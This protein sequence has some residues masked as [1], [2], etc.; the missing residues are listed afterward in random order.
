VRAVLFDLDDTLFDHRGSS[1]AALAEVHRHHAPGTDFAAFER[2]HAEILEELHLEVLDGRRDLDDARR[3]RFRRVFAAMDVRLPEDNADAVAA[4]YRSG[5]VPAWRAVEGAAALVAA[6]RPHARIGVISNNLLAETR[7]KLVFCDLLP[8]VDALVVS[9]D[10]GIAKPDP[11]IFHT[12][13]ERLGVTAA[14]AVMV[15]DSWAADIVGAARAG[16]HPVWFNPRRRPRP[17]APADVTEVHTLAPVE[18]LLPILL[19]GPGQG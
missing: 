18:A 5:Y 1:R 3:E 2:H 8:L 4:A 17:G 16:I 9:G 13:L 15:G 11:R 10:E 7:D 19:G 6:V 12:A 14:D